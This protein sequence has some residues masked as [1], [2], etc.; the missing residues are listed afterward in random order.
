MIAHHEI[1]NFNL[2]LNKFPRFDENSKRGTNPFKF[3]QT[4]RGRIEFKIEPHFG[5][6]DFKNLCKRQKTNAEKIFDKEQTLFCQNYNTTWRLA[7]GL[8]YESV[9]ETNITLHHIYGIP[10]I[11][12]S[13]LKGVVRS[14]IITQAF[15][16]VDGEQDLAKA[17]KKALMNKEFCDIFGCDSNSYYKKAMQGNITFFDAFPTTIPN[18]EP[19]VMNPHYGPYYQD[20]D[21]KKNIAPVDY[22]MPVPV[23]FLTVKDTTFQFIIGSKDKNWLDWKIDGK[24]IKEWLNDALTQHGIGAKTAVGYGYMKKASN[25]N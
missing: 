11:P 3:F 15:G 2:K 13:S 5:E 12:A 8:G 4:S 23:N 24:N 25:S 21:N 16:D 20:A 1:D 18:I 22:H 14:W 19:D 17:E 6:F 9:Y 7:I 10:Y